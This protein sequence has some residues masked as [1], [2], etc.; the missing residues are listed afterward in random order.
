MD[1]N[2]QPEVL[3]AALKCA[4]PGARAQLALTT[5]RALVRPA[6]PPAHATAT[7]PPCRKLSVENLDNLTPHPLHVML[8][9]THPPMLARISAIR[10]DAARGKASGKAAR[11]QTA[12]M[13]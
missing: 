10:E 3:I 1:T 8:N 12:A 5:P 9:Y 6:P 4:S 2:G 7:P 13:V 11:D